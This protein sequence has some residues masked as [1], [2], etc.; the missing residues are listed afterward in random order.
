MPREAP[1]TVVIPSK[2]KPGSKGSHKP[3]KSVN[4]AANGLRVDG[5]E[6]KDIALWMGTTPSQDLSHRAAMPPTLPS[7]PKLKSEEAAAVV[8]ASEQEILPGNKDGRIEDADEEQENDEES[9][10]SDGGLG[11]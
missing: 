4:R 5:N 1:E 3:Y 2:H 10:E 8:A 6:S 11:T 7:D 9:G